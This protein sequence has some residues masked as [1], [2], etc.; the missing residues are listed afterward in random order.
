MTGFRRGRQVSR[1][2]SSDGSGCRTDTVWTSVRRRRRLL[3]SLGNTKGRSPIK[4]QDLT[5]PG[6]EVQRLP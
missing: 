3:V 2:R 5:N 6:S 4:G 1:V